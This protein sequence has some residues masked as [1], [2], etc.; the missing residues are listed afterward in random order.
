MC[1]KE[2]DGWSLEFLIK[3][4]YKMDIG[5]CMRDAKTGKVTQLYDNISFGESLFKTYEL[6][7]KKDGNWY[8]IGKATNH[9]FMG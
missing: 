2:L 4:D 7:R 8:W 5:V 1:L 9:K 6:R 3:E